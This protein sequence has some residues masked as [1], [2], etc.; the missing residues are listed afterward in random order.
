MAKYLC[1]ALCVPR[2]LVFVANCLCI[3][4][5]LSRQSSYMWRIAY[6]KLNV[7]LDN[8]RTCEKVPV[9]CSKCA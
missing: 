9:Y 2:H 7:C 6:V 1:I 4:R 5:S 3:A 8:S